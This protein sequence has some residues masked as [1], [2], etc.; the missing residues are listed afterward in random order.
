M[1]YKIVS[2]AAFLTILAIGAAAYISVPREKAAADERGQIE[3]LFDGNSSA[4]AYQLLKDE[5][6]SGEQAAQH[7]AGHIFGEFLYRDEGLDGF[8]VCD[9]AL[10][11]GCYHTFIAAAIAEHGED[12]I[13]TLDA[14]CVGAF[15]EG[16]LGCFHG[17]GHGL[18]SYEGYRTE[19]VARALELCAGLSWQR[20]LGGCSDGVFMENNFRVMETDPK[21]RNR[22]FTL[23]DRHEPCVSIPEKHRE[24][25]YFSQPGWW[26]QGQN[27]AQKDIAVWCGEAAN[28]T[29]RRSC[30]RGAGYAQAPF[31]QFD[32][33]RGIAYCDAFPGSGNGRLWCREGL[34]WA[35]YA[36]P[37]LRDR[38][39]IVCSDGL[40]AVQSK[41]CQD[42]YLFVIQ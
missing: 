20:P 39:E 19:D 33:T 13:K 31:V 11:F 6:Q 22:P 17:I 27:R 28:E 30:F 5:Y 10:G 24:A 12:V 4:E 32:A 7:N 26:M 34:A 9:G 25:C 3:A 2:V 16:G 15:G 29:L 21:D 18:L 14:T 8:S 36:D 38:A 23:E 41:Q 35:L 40:T 37:A 1:Q 42:E